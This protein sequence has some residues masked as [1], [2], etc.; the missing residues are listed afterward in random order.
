MLHSSAFHY[1]TICTCTLST[2]AVGLNTY[3]RGAWGTPVYLTQFP[4]TPGGGTV[5]LVRNTLHGFLIT[6]DAG[7]FSYLFPYHTSTLEIR[8]IRTTSGRVHIGQVHTYTCRY[9]YKRDF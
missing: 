8:D 6:A 5:V 4:F 9:L 7:S 3:M 1:Y 2:Q